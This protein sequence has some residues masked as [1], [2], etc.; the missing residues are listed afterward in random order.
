MTSPCRTDEDPTSNLVFKSPSASTSS[1]ELTSCG[2][3][4][5]MVAGVHGA[6]VMVPCGCS[7]DVSSSI[8][9]R[10]MEL[11]TIKTEPPS[12]S[13]EISCKNEIGRIDST[14]QAV[15][16]ARG[17]GGQSPT[18]T[19]APGEEAGHARSLISDRF[20]ISYQKRHQKTRDHILLDKTE[21][22][23]RAFPGKRRE[24]WFE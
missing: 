22:N 10:C 14:H 11:R 20:L 16:T 3:I 8:T 6:S 7:V 12:K 5:R 21:A 9:H 23:D 17:G 24:I 19:Q 13:T 18:K 2:A 1:M 15:R 4:G